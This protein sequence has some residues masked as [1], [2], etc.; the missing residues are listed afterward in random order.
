M[1][2]SR[3]VVVTGG[4]SGIGRAAAQRFGADGDH[5]IIADL[6]E[7]GAAVVADTIVEAGGKAR[8][9][10][11]DVADEKSV[12]LA[13]EE[14]TAT[15]GPPEVLINSAGLLQDPVTSQALDM[16]EHDRIWQVNYR[17]TYLCCRAFGRIM[18][19]RASGAIVNLASINSYR[20]LP[21]PA[22]TYCNVD[23]SEQS[24]TF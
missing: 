12:G 18:A 17:G 7:S 9:I 10:A 24:W 20:V 13:A 2:T 22:Y 4:A 19:D 23:I 14:I 8:A 1:A 16:A 5:V 3:I 11:I 21:L 6:N 15:D